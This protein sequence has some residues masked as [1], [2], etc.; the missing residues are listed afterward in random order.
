MLLGLTVVR[1]AQDVRRGVLED[2]IGPDGFAEVL[3]GFLAVVGALLVIRRLVWWRRSVNGRVYADGGEGDE[4]GLPVSA[5][6]PFVMLAVGLAW[7]LM[8]PRIGFITA[9]WVACCAAVF[10]MRTRSVIKLV[11]V[12]IC[13]SLLTWILFS[14]VSGL[15]LPAGPVD[16]FFATFIPR[17]G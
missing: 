4:P 9:T 13:F 2:P 11:V 5:I 7:A 17:L 1:L 8:L 15:R 14:R 16:L 12:P 10:A 3:G 6:R